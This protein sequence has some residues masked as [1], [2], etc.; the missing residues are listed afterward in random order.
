MVI[1]HINC[2]RHPLHS[3]HEPGSGMDVIKQQHHNHLIKTLGCQD[4]KI[5]CSFDGQ[6]PRLGAFIVIWLIEVLYPHKIKICDSDIIQ[7]ISRKL[8]K[9]LS[10]PGLRVMSG[11]NLIWNEMLISK[12]SPPSPALIYYKAKKKRSKTPL[13]SLS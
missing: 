13:C 11:E 7:F 12:V 4:F 3:F 5:L 9:S 1:L 10:S 2:H 8:D 6:N